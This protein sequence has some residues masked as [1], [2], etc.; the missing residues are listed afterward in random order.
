LSYLARLGLRVLRR[1]RQDRTTEAVVQEYSDGW[2]QYEQYLSASTTLAEWLT[3][4]NVDDA[5]CYFNFEGRL[6]YGNFNPRY[7]REA[8]VAAL[9]S[10]FPGAKS[11]TEFGSGVGRNLLYLKKEIPAL[12]VYGYELCPP[13][14]KI[15]QAAAAKFGLSAA[16]AP[17]DYLN[18]PPE[19]FVFPDTDVAFTMFSLEQIP[20]RVS[21]ALKNILSRSRLGS[22][23]IEPV[24]ENYPVT[25]RGIMGRIDHWK[26]NY[27]SGFDQAARD[28]DHVTAAVAPMASSH[29]PLMFPSLYVLKKR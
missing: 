21:E 2:R 14:V 28:I 10:H 19:K 6:T 29:N 1:T 24:P 26:V 11:I 27:L 22:I 3:I 15:A 25:V 13:G 16:Y 12:E 7:Y 4:P 20:T 23:H 18:D 5:P 9:R 17:L 8:L